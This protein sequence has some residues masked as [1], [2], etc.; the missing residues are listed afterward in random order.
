MKKRILML[1]LI[2]LA[3][4]SIS[5]TVKAADN[6]N[7]QVQRN[8]YSNN[9]SMKFSFTGLNLNITHE[10]E[11]GFTKTAAAQ[12]TKWYLITEYTDSTAI[13]DI[14]T[15]T[16][17]LREVI[18]TV[19]IGYITIKDKTL[20]EVV[21]QPYAVNL[22]IPYLQ[23]TNYTVMNNGK[24]LG[25]NQGDCINVALRNASDSEAYYQYEKITNKNVIE[26]YKN[27]KNKN[28]NYLELEPMLKTS[29]PTAN[30]KSWRYWNEHSVTG[31]NGY[32]YPESPIKAP[33]TGLY[34]MWLSFSGNNLKPL[35]GVIL[36]D[37]LQPEVAVESISLPKTATV[38]LGTIY[39]IK[40]VINPSGATN[41]I[42]TWSSSDES[43]ATVDNAGRITP[44]KI[45]ST[46][47]T[48]TTQDGNKKA[49]CTVTVIPATI[50]NNNGGSSNGS[51][52]DNKDDNTTATG[53]L[54]QTGIGIE[55]TVIMGLVAVVG[56]ISYVGYRRLKG[57]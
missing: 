32:G 6:T 26:K 55:I 46:I 7:V 28:G 4:L 22:R 18:N 2:I 47:I 21:L 53:K 57:V 42:I 38:K 34:Y 16:E 45:G 36:V 24:E 40:Y 20:D 1:G 14:T 15:T 39:T 56:I 17:G 49:T 50:I 10:Y 11:Y 35:Y 37:N 5:V 12:V 52:N 31:M 19:D 48:A 41:K 30:W 43:V 54:P 8:I 25:T 23:V 27:I 3:I 9:G 13:I 44:K 51:T 29:V 33:D